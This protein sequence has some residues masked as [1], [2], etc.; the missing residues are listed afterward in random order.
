MVKGKI[1]FMSPEQANGQALDERSDLFS[2]GTVLYL[3]TTGVRP[4][5][6]A[7][8]FEII[9][10]VQKCLLST[11]RAGKPGN[12]GVAGGGHPAGVDGR[13]RP[14]LP[15]R[16]TSSW[17]IIEAVWR[18]EYGAPGQTE[19]K[20]WL[21]ELTRID[22]SAPLGRTGIFGPGRDGGSP[23]DLAEGARAGPGRRGLGA[24]DDAVGGRAGR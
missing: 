10:R 5:E 1:A 6:A 13:S 12:A 23:G 11:A 15:H 9:A 7:T 24:G 18:S 2:L 20:L 22:G 8:D 4:F 21:A 14:A 17:S 16:L 3:L 19:L